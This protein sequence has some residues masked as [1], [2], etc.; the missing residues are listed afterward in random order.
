MSD[1]DYTSLGVAISM[2]G[3]VSSCLAVEGRKIGP[4]IRVLADWLV[5]EEKKPEPWVPDYDETYW[6]WEMRQIL[7]RQLLSEAAHNELDT[8][9]TNLT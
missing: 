6:K 9:Q 1:Y 4:M 3:D 5:P 8:N 7:R 2:A